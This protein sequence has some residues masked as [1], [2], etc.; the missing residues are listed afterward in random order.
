LKGGA[1][2]VAADIVASP[3]FL[4]TK[5]SQFAA[6]APPAPKAKVLLTTAIQVAVRWGMIFDM[7][8]SRSCSQLSL[9]PLTIITAMVRTFR[10]IPLIPSVGGCRLPALWQA[11]NGVHTEQIEAIVH[12]RSGPHLSVAKWPVANSR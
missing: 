2:F 7:F 6:T 5:P 8:R 11:F 1:T 10:T 4:P 3:K 9:K 12:E